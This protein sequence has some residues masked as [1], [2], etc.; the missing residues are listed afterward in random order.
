MPLIEGYTIE[1]FRFETA[2]VANL[3]LG[4]TFTAQYRLI[5]PDT[6]PEASRTL[7]RAFFA[8]LDAEGLVSST[9]IAADVEDDV[10]VNVD[11]VVWNGSEFAILL[12]LRSA[13][14]TNRTQ[15]H[16]SSSTPIPW[17][18]TSFVMP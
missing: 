2:S 17:S 3:E 1:T 10:S 8:R 11:K 13:V 14:A 12:G 16:S 5:D 7:S 9:T 15:P 18:E 4:V 6:N